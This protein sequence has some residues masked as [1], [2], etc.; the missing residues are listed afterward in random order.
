M[1]NITKKDPSNKSGE[2]ISGAVK[3]ANIKNVMLRIK[4]HKLI[5][6]LILI[7]VIIVCVGIYFLFIKE[8]PVLTVNGVKIYKS[9]IT[10]DANLNKKAWRA[11][12]K[13]LSEKEV[14]EKAKNHLKEKEEYYSFGQRIK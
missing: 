3:S 12:N 8:R 10:K 2:V 6:A 13:N 5:T 14:Y 4:N 7:I 11:S 1:I 9:D